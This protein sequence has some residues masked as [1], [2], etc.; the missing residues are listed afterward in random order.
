MT[1]N[2]KT[3][4]QQSYCRACGL[5]VIDSVCPYCGSTIEEP[6]SYESKIGY[7]S[8]LTSI[9]G[10]CF[11]IL[12]GVT[13]AIVSASEPNET[14]SVASPPLVVSAT[15]TSA[16]AMESTSTTLV[17][18]SEEKTVQ[19]TKTPI[20]QKPKKTE[21]TSS[22]SVYV[23]PSVITTSSSSTSSSTSTSTSIPRMPHGKKP[24]TTIIW[25]SADNDFKIFVSVGT[26][27]NGRREVDSVSAFAGHPTAEVISPNCTSDA[28]FY[29]SQRYVS[30]DG[31][32]TVLSADT[33][34]GPKEVSCTTSG[35]GFGFG[36]SDGYW[37]WSTGT[38]QENG[39][40][41]RNF[42]AKMKFTYLETKVVVESPWVLVDWAKIP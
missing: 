3:S 6:V 11:L 16:Q 2:N 7:R 34:L 36:W 12:A 5:I 24:G 39:S 21:S 28:E 23:T 38:R 41:P 30:L 22:I 10:A 42:Y 31:G 4:R 25:K 13:P 1:R 33:V 27:W 26:S 18:S 15:T 37:Y 17:Q 40:T 14:S 8:R 29:R 35:L 19:N 20:T 32:A 9:T